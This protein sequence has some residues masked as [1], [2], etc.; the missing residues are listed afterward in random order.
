MEKAIKNA[1]RNSNAFNP[2]WHICNNEGH[3]YVNIISIPTKAKCHPIFIR[4]SILWVEKNV[5]KVIA[6]SVTRKIK[7]GNLG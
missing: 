7:V 6:K 1:S 3:R 5:L 4:V 2:S